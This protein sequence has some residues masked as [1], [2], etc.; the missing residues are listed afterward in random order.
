MF[1]VSKKIVVIYE[2]TTLYFI[3]TALKF[4]KSKNLTGVLFQFLLFNT[5]NYRFILFKIN[6]KKIFNHNTKNLR[7][8]KLLAR[9][10]NLMNH[11]LPFV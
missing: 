5:V 3:H 11:V 4:T 2:Y 6:I 1:T 9:Q 10:S 8:V 7:S